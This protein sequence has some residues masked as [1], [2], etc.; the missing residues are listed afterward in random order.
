MAGSREWM[1]R[2]ACRGVPSEVFFPV[3]AERAPGAHEYALARKLCARCPVVEPCRE[4]G[5]H[6]PLGMW[7]GLTPTE[8]RRTAWSSTS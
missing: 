6:E 1:G 4:A 7:G 3:A 8:R 5:S 2:A